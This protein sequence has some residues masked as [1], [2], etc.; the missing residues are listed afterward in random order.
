MKLGTFRALSLVGVGLLTVAAPARS[1]E[2]A[3]LMLAPMQALSLDFGAEHIVGYFLDR[4]N[5]CRLNLAIA[6][7]GDME[8]ANVSHV[9]F[10]V[11]VGG[12][13]HLES[14]PG[15]SLSFSCDNGAHRMRIHRSDGLARIRDVD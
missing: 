2:L 13:A 10:A 12:V 4:G 3:P 15:G 11:S 8:A 9:A 14:S 5:H 7:V 1:E 6:E